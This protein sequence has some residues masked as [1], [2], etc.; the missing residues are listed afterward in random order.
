VNLRFVNNFFDFT[1]FENPIK[2]FI[3]DRIYFPIEP[4]TKKLCEF[5]VKRA[6]TELYDSLVPL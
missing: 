3:E 1:D 5:F 2:S 6:H 4:H